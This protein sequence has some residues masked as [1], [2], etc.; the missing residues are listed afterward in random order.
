MSL[1]E[2]LLAALEIL[3]EG[4]DERDEAQRRKDGNY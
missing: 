1:A 4:G 3:D 2:E